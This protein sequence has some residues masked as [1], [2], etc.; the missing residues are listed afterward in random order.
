LVK[1]KEVQIM[2]SKRKSYGWGVACLI[3]A[4]V[5]FTVMGETVFRNWLAFA[6]CAANIGCALWAG[7]GFIRSKRAKQSQGKGIEQGERC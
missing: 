4:V 2:A 6:V 7:I 5:M 3:A 1:N